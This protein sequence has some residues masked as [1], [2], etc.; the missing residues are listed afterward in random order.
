MSNLEPSPQSRNFRQATLLSDSASTDDREAVKGSSCYGK[1]GGGAEEEGLEDLKPTPDALRTWGIWNFVFMW[2]SMAV[3]VP[4][5]MLGASLLSVGLNWW[6]ATITVFVGSLIVLVPLILNGHSGVAYA[7]SFPVFRV[8]VSVCVARFAALSRGI[9]GVGWFAFQVWGA[10]RS[11][12][13]TAV[14]RLAAAQRWAIFNNINVAQLLAFVLSGMS[15]G[16]CA[17]GRH[18][19]RQVHSDTDRPRGVRSGLALFIWF[20]VQSA[21]RN[22]GGYLRTADS[23]PAEFWTGFWPALSAILGSW[24]ARPQYSRPHATALRRVRPLVRRLACHR[25]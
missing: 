17:C 19:R 12:R 23:K 14:F 3:G 6:Q 4:T 2:S 18:S 22:A 13:S 20:A 25:R 1:C 15:C 7:I 10:L 16:A 9:V 24:A 21:F 8:R 11:T 5:Y